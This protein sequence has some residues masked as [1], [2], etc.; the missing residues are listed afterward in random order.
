MHRPQGDD[1]NSSPYTERAEIA[2]GARLNPIAN[3]RSGLL[4][5]VA[6]FALSFEFRVLLRRQ[7]SFCRF[8]EF[9]LT[10]VVA[11]SLVM[12]LHGCV[13]FCFLIGCE[14]QTRHGNRT[15]HL[16]FVADLLCAVAMFPR[17][18]SGCRKESRRY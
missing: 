12:L 6:F 11:A 17:E 5:F 9:G 4:T 15:R 10:G 8:H 18:H 16:R 13:H 2:L 14:V 3:R 1:Y 7:D